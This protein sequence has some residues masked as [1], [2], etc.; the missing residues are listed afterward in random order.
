[1]AIKLIELFKTKLNEEGICDEDKAC[2]NR[3]A[4]ITVLRTTVKKAIMT[5][6]Y[7]VSVYQMI[8][9]LK[10]HFNKNINNSDKG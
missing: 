7:N 10:E 4:N 8:K 9:Y 6:P 5:V 3:L 2:Y 1:M